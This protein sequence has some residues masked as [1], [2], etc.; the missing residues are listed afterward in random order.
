MKKGNKNTSFFHRITSIR[1]SLNLINK[2]RVGVWEDNSGRIRNQ[3]KQFYQ[4]LYSDPFPY[5]PK[6]EG[7]DF[8]SINDK[9]QRW[10][11]RPF[12][13]EKVMIA[14]NGME[15]DKAP[16]PDG[17]PIGFLSLLGCGG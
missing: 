14:L 10:L 13:K 2:L 16:R 7:V 8:D 5:R 12:S 4:N 11:E 9:D 6:I 1:K 15:G 17:F 3:I